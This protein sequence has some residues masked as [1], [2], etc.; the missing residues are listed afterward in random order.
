MV[1]SFVLF[2][3]TCPG[4]WDLS[5]LMRPVL[6]YEAC[7]SLWDLSWFIKPVLVHETCINLLLL[8]QSWSM[9]LVQIPNH[10]TCEAGDSN[11]QGKTRFVAKNKLWHLTEWSI[12][13]C[14]R[15]TWH[16]PYLPFVIKTIISLSRCV[17]LSSNWIVFPLSCHFHGKI[18]LTKSCCLTGPTLKKKFHNQSFITWILLSET[19]FYICRSQ[20]YHNLI[21]LYIWTYNIFFHVLFLILLFFFPLTPW[22]TEL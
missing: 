10:T 9:T 17:E 3:D 21:V 15:A 1:T 8:D 18:K 5:W 12:A 7:P 11:E 22:L 2:C 16:F 13:G 19:F 4:L 6:V 14:S 20:L